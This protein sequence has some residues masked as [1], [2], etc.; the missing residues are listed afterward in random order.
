MATA[1]PMMIRFLEIENAVEPMRFIDACKKR[2]ILDMDLVCDP[3]S[4]E[5]SV[6]IVRMNV[7]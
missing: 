3:W 5:A 6:K 7:T 2:G 1:R 4:L